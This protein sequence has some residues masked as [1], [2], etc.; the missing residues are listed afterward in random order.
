MIRVF[1]ILILLSIISFG[2]FNF[3]AQKD[4]NEVSKPVP[5]MRGPVYNPLRQKPYLKNT[6]KV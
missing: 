1:N 4:E 5:T 3:S 6:A 2:R